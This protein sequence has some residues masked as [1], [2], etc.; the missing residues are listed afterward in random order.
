M[1]I[2]LLMQQAQRMQKEVESNIKKAKEELA[3]LKFTLKQVVSIVKVTMT[4]RHVVKRI[5][6][7]PELLQ[8]D[9]DMIE[10]LNCSSN[11]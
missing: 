1:N 11:Q 6:T 8:D 10:K 7:N 9:A 5:E 2:H 3:Q 4:A